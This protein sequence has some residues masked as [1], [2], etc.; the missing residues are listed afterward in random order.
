MKINWNDIFNKNYQKNKGVTDD[1]LQIFLR[2]WNI[3]LSNIEYNEMKPLIVKFGIEKYD[4]PQ[5]KLPLS[6]IDF[7]KYSNGGDFSNKERYF[8]FFNVEELR[9]YNLAYE[10]PIYMNG[11]LSIAM[12]GCGNHILFDMRDESVDGEYPVVVSHSGSLGV[13]EDDYKVIGKSFLDVCMDG[14]I[15]IDDFAN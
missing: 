9:T 11:F 5:R 13:S 2:T 4:F 14:S 15:S 6:Y 1:E 10:T 7:L 3:P 8:Q 12:D